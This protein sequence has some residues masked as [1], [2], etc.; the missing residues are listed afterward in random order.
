MCSR[1]QWQQVVIQVR[2]LWGRTGANSWDKAEHAYLKHKEIE[3]IPHDA[4]V[5]AVNDFLSEGLTWAPTISQVIARARAGMDHR[6]MPTPD[7]CRHETLGVL[8]DVT[9]C[10][11]CGK[12]WENNDE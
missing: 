12:E 7:E 10:A 5:A 11:I 6:P 2:N 4:L 8:S 3:R 1:F 9:I